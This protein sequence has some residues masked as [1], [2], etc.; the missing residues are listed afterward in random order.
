M[1]S[2]N[3][4]NHNAE[5]WLLQDIS[6]RKWVPIVYTETSIDSNDYMLELSS[7]LNPV[8]IWSS[9]KASNPMYDKH[10]KH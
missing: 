9:A 10:K 2:H 3:L 1:C 8:A 7:E 5:Y 6:D 4:I